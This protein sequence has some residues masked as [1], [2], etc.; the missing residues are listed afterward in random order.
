MTQEEK[1]PVPPESTY[2]ELEDEEDLD[3]AELEELIQAVSEPDASGQQT[4]PENDPN[5]A[6]IAKMKQEIDALR[7]QV[8]EKEDNYMRLYADFDNFRKRTQ[9]EKEGLSWREQQKVILDV[10]PVVD[11]FERAQQAIKVETDREKS[12][13]ESYQ[14]VYRLL[15]EGLKKM[16]V[17]RMKTVGEPFNPNL[18]EAMMQQPTAESPEGTVLQEFQPGYL[19]GDE[20]L[21]HA[22]V[23]VAAPAD[24]EE[25]SSAGET[26]STDSSESEDVSEGDDVRS[27]AEQG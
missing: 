9:R 2:P 17:S 5:A 24:R 6:E 4:S 10:L 22:M 3:E 20:V 19:L 21:R 12:I 27:E 13:H 11:N 25:E 7:Q 14:S 26:D 15:V 16:G 18:H 8:L 23:I 1:K